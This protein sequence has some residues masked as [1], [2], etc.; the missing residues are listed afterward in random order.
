MGERPTRLVAHTPPEGSDEWH[1]LDDHLRDVAEMAAS[2]A[3]PFGGQDLAWWAGIYHDAGKA[4]DDFQDY[5]WKCF[6]EPKHRYVSLYDGEKLWRLWEKHFPPSLHQ[7]L[8]VVQR[9]IAGLDTEFKIEATV[10]P[11]EQRKYAT[12]LDRA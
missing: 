1:Y 10:T 12:P 4:Q 11:T 3:A 6:D 8:E 5:L 9:R 2:F 7:S